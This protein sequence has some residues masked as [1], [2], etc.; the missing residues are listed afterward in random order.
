MNYLRI[1]S[2]GFAGYTGYLGQIEFKDGVSVDPVPEVFANRLAASMQ[3]MNV[4]AD[5]NEIGPAG[6]AHKLVAESANRA[7]V[8]NRLDR[9]SNSDRRDEELR[10]HLRAQ[11]PPV[12]HFYTGEELEKVVEKDGIK[13]LR[14]IGDRWNVRDRSIPGLIQQIIGAQTQFIKKRDL[15]LQQLSERQAAAMQ[16]AEQRKIDEAAK[17]AAEEAEAEKLASV[18]SGH[19]D[20]AEVYT[21][22]S[23]VIPAAVIID[24]AWKASNLS[25]TGWNNLDAGKR[26][27]FILTEIERLDSFY[28]EKLQAATVDVLKEKEEAPADFLLG[29]SVLAATYEIAGETVQLGDIVASAFTLF[30]GTI[31]EWNALQ[32]DQ[33]EDL[34]RLEL[35]RRLAAVE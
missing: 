2:K 34:L 15:R 11:K 35:D 18:L 21:A 6:V 3:M 7:P 20:L 14:D 17:K 5:G 12:D 10:D 1:E 27:G 13:G 16:E 9:Q 29:S 24:N 25:L 22:G 19:E 32:E 23:V 31:D 30:G 26:Q 33:R 4:D 28:G 8:A